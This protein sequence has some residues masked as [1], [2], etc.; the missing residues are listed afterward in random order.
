MVTGEMVTEFGREI[1]LGKTPE[2]SKF[3]PLD[4]EQA[5]CWFRMERDIQAAPPGA[6]VDLPWSCSETPEGFDTYSA[7]LARHRESRAAEELKK[8]QK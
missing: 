4:A 5:E 6:T 7:D 1:L 3:A 8:I 2:Q